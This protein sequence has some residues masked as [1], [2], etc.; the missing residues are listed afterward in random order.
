MVSLAPPPPRKTDKQ[1]SVQSMMGSKRNLS[2]HREISSENSVLC[3]IQFRLKKKRFYQIKDNKIPY[4][5][6]VP[7][8]SY[9]AFLRFS[10]QRASR[11]N[12]K[13][14][15]FYICHRYSKQC[16]LILTKESKTSRNVPKH[17]DF[18]HQHQ[19]QWLPED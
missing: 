1:A 6:I 16:Y 17:L 2:S 8:N 19:C 4:Q 13:C 10:F 3:R 11:L 5:N 15:F 18:L 14:I 9:D 12:R 7:H